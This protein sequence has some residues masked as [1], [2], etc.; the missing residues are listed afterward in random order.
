MVLIILISSIELTFHQSLNACLY[1]HTLAEEKNALIIQRSKIFK[2][3]TVTDLLF[4]II[5]YVG[6]VRASAPR[7]HRVM[8]YPPAIHAET[9]IHETRVSFRVT[10]KL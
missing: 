1:I 7:W 8:S 4:I 3:R 10:T 6:C 2:R 9:F 5:M